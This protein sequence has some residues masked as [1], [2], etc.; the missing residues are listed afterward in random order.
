M[1]L[2]AAHLEQLMPRLTRTRYLL[3]L[4]PDDR[5]EVIQESW[6][7]VCRRLQKD[8]RAMDDVQ[9][10][11]RLCS[12]LVLNAKRDFI[13][14]TFRTRVKPGKTRAL[15]YYATDH[16]TGLTDRSARPE[17]MITCDEW[18]ELIS[19]EV[20]PG[21]ARACALKSAGHTID[22]IAARLEIK[23]SRVRRWLKLAREVVAQMPGPHR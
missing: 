18:L 16:L 15:V 21:A 9:S 7:R 14:K 5:E 11:D 19:L 1:G 2:I 12:T 20:G 17:D 13:R 10:W 6:L 4:T 8:P 22:E 3:D 23:V